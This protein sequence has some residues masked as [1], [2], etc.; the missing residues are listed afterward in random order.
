M[1]AALEKSFA[2]SDS[3]RGG[4]SSL[5][6]SLGRG[7]APRISVHRNRLASAHLQAAALASQAKPLV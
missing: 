3:A 1:L 5:T 7:M 2:G 6:T 4:S